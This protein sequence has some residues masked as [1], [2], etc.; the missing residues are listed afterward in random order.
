MFLTS[1]RADTDRS[2]WGDFWF[3]PVGGRSS[4]GMRVT[5]EQAMRLTAVYACVRN[6][7]EDFAKLPFRMFR[8]A[9][10]LAPRTPVTEH[11]LLRLICKK[12]NR[13][14]TPFNWRE[15]MQ[16]HLAL[17]GNA[18]NELVV[19]GQGEVTDLLPIHPDRVKIE[20]LDNGS[21]RFRVKQRD[22]TEIVY[23]R[24][25]IWHIKGLS[26]D[27]YVGYNPIELQADMLGA[28]MSA[29]EY[30]GRFFA[31]DAR[32]SGGWVEI[33][34]K[35]ADQAARKTFQ[36][37]W[38]QGQGGKNRG[39][40]AM[41]EGGMKYHDPVPVSNRDSQFIEARQM[42]IA[43]I[44]RMFRQPPHKI[45][46]L[47][48][49]TFSNIEQQSIEYGTDTMSPWCERWES[50]IECDLLGED[51]GFEVEFD[52]RQLMRGDSAARVT[53]YTGGI[54]GGWLTRNEARAEEGLDPIDGLD[55]P[56]QPLNMVEVGADPMQGSGPSG[57]PANPG[58]DDAGA[59]RLNALL[60]GNAQR[61]ARRIV[62]AG[63]LPS[64]AV[65]AESMAVTL[66][67]A[68]NWMDAAAAEDALPEADLTASLLAL[69]LHG[70]LVEPSPSAVLARGMKDG[71][72]A[73]ASALQARAAP[74]INVTTPDNRLSV[75]VPVTLEARVD[76]TRAVTKTVVSERLA[77]GSIISKVTEQ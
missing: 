74:V 67:A 16:G 66:G 77:D 35:F 29:Q 1:V 37:S 8:Q 4:S 61:M 51:S 44:A 58:P 73:I 23:R 2:P 57:A 56:L 69:G 43:D 72:R 41:L 33:P 45:G 76:A 7:S 24:D 3:T 18:F 31:N 22:G 13:W 26:P 20:L 30:A 64:P 6:L 40:T 55:E 42:T 36:E 60:Q 52:L 12:P 68:T 65:I 70:Q 34:G 46:D 11:W 9:D 38:Q 27:G 63:K 59:A 49:A 15:M 47:S 75:T 10:E 21:Y 28:G 54:N 32:P 62:A 39:K 5:A 71:M 17:R 50:S 25:E 48:K 53:Y 14:Q 19:D